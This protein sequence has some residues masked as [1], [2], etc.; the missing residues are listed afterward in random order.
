MEWTEDVIQIWNFAPHNV[1]SN[2]AS[3]MPDTSTW[4]EPVFTTAGGGC[5][6]DDYFLD[7]S[8]VFDTTFCGDFAGQPAQWELT[9]CYINNQDLYPT[10]AAYVAA[11]PS[12]YKDAYW[13]I[14]SLKVYQ[15]TDVVSSTSSTPSST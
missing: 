7:H 8:V 15:K 12:V 13:I 9:T 3:G 14:N 2:L 1:P 10:C 11:N 4:P 6:I 5:N